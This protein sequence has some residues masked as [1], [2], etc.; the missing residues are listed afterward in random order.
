M[1]WYY[2]SA[3]AAAYFAGAI[4]TGVWLVRRSAG[5]DLMSS[6]TGSSGARNSYDVTGKLWISLVVF[7]VDFLKGVLAVGFARWLTYENFTVA[8][9]AAVFV[10]LGHN[11]NPF[12][13]FRG[14][15]GLSPAA[16]AL[17]TISVFPVGLWLLMW[18]TGWYVIKKNV[19]VANVTALATSPLLLFSAPDKIIYLT[20]TM[21]F[22]DMMGFRWLY[23]AICFVALIKHIDPLLKLLK[24]KK[25]VEAK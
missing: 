24:E 5:I 15:R 4:P 12:L 1:T 19:H 13:K 8:A 25:P 7:L 16:G 14:G 9:L 10:V 23:A 18:V 11:F 22:K 20:Q 6:G 2:I 3:M 17:A 21:S